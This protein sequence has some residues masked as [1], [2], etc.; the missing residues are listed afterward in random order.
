[1]S[2]EHFDLLVVGGGKGG[3]TLAARLAR[4]GRRVAMVERGMIGG[5]CINVACIPTKT[6]V[7]SAKVVDLARRAARHGIR[8]EVAPVDAVAVRARK[9]EVVAE[10]V[11]RNR[12]AFDDS[13]LELILGTARFVAPKTVAVRLAGG[14]ER[15]LFGEQVVVNTGTRPSAPDVPGLAAAG[16][17]DSELIQELDRIPE[18]LVVLGGGVIGCELG[19][20]F[21]RF[22]S[23][24]VIVDRNE[25]LMP[26]EEPEVVEELRHAFDEDGIEVVT[27]ASVSEVAGRSGSEVRVR[28][29]S[30]AGERAIEGTHLLVALGRVPNTDGLDAASAGIELDERGF[31]RVNDRLETT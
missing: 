27:G 1:M 11:A 9:R 31:V 24:V 15:T 23:R 8:I 2:T 13:G 22:G 3:K 19:Q 28:V 18:R 21:A 7:R 10:M 6:L 26:R 16:A 17:L 12:K 4:E 14:G 25:R 30:G 29:R 5:S 20:V